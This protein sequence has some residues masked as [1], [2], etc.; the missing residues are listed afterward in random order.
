MVK[1]IYFIMILSR[2]W[3]VP[4]FQ[5]WGG[6]RSINDFINEY[7]IDDTKKSGYEVPIKQITNLSLWV[8]MYTLVRIMGSNSLH[9]ASGEQMYYGVEF[10]HPTMYDWST[11]MLNNM[12]EQ[13]TDYKLRKTN[14]FYFGS[15]LYTFFFE[16]VPMMSPQT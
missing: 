12:K 3:E 1:Y 16:Q 13:L 4:K 9:L 14:K 8:I 15:V 2:I 6:C 5:Y 11:T 7:C 10:L